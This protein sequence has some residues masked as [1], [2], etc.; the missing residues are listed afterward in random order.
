MLLPAAVPGDEFALHGDGIYCKEDH[1]LFERCEDNNNLE[2]KHHHVTSPRIKTELV[3]SQDFRDNL[4]D[5]GREDDSYRCIGIE[6]F[7]LD[8]ETKVHQK[9]RNHREGPY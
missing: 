7:L 9:V 8:L 1:E 4:S 2:V 3:D 6:V 5:L